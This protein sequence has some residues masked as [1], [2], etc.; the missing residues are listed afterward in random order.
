MTTAV[1]PRP[2]LTAAQY[3]ARERKSDVRHE[4]VNGQIYAM[5]GESRDHNRVALNIAARLFAAARGGPSRVSFETVRL[6]VGADR[7]YYPDVMVACGP[8]PDDPY[9]ETAPCLIVE[10]L[11]PSTQRTDR[12]EKGPAYRALPSLQ[13]YVV[14]HQPRRRVEWYT[15]AADGSWLVANVVGDGRI[16]FPCPPTADSAPVTMTVDE[17]YDGVAP[18]PPRAPRRRPPSA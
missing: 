5:A 9:V 13:T 8:P 7:E 11:S 14:V 17:I 16:T 6:V 3:H 15:R 1:A 2:L 18:P 12:R 4:Y 10:V